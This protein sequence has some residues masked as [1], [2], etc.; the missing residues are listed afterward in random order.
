MAIEIGGGIAASNNNEDEDEFM[1]LAVPKSVFTTD[2]DKYNINSTTSTWNDNVTGGA[3]GLHSYI[4][5]GKKEELDITSESLPLTLI[6]GNNVEVNN[7]GYQKNVA[8]GSWNSSFYSQ[9]SF[10]PNDQDFAI[11]WLVEST[12]GTIREM[13]GLAANPSINDSYSSIDYAVYQVNATFYYVVYESGRSSVTGSGSVAVAVGDRIGIKVIDNKVTYYIQKGDEI[14]DIYT[15]LKDA[16]A[17]LFFKAALNRGTDLS[18]HSV[19][20]N[21][22]YHTNTKTVIKTTDISGLA[23]ESITSDDA[24]RLAK[25]GIIPEEGTLYS[26]IN[27]TKPVSTRFPSNTELTYNHIYSVNDAQDIQTVTI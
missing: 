25:L 24:D 6:A 23:N 21:C 15:S 18:G 20:T 27:F 9:E 11:S 17:P 3:I 7:D 5:T 13:C 4:F 2:A 12:S 16:K 8:G 14:T 1:P 19:V 22:Q 26:N 10:N